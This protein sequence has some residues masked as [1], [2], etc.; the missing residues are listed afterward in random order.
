MT[1]S[2][3]RRKLLYNKKC[4]FVDDLTV[5]KPIDLKS[6]LRKADEKELVRPLNFHQRTEQYLPLEVNY[7]QTE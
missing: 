2:L 5:T 1:T 4:K 7:M 3:N 6:K